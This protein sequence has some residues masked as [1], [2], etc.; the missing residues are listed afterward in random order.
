MG[1]FYAE[2]EILGSGSG[3]STPMLVVEM[4]VLLKL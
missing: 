4:S 2:G 1:F 3:D